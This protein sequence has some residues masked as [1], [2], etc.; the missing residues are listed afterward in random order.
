MSAVTYS[1][2]TTVETVYIILGNA[3]ANH[4]TIGKVLDSY[5]CPSA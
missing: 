4:S 1:E 3:L 5:Q 2:T